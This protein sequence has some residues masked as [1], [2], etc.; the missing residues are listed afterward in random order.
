F[1]EHLL[2]LFVARMLLEKVQQ[3]RSCLFRSLLLRIDSGKIQIWLIETRRNPDALFKTRHRIIAPLR[4]Q[5]EYAE[6][7]QSF[8][9]NG[10]S[11]L[12]PLQILVGAIRIVGLCK[13]NSK[14]VILLD[15]MMIYF[16]GGF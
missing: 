13:D 11:L 12:C 16:Q 1:V 15:I 9:I 3:F 7:V 8:R 14:A 2:R 4:N 5:I 6:V 10:S